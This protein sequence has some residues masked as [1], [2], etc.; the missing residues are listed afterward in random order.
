V[1]QQGYILNVNKPKG[2]TSFDV[3]RHVRQI[4]GIK[5][6]GHAGTLDPLAEGVLIILIGRGATK[7]SNE[8][9]GKRKT[10][11][12]TFRLGVKTRTHDLEAEIEVDEE[13]DISIEQVEQA[14]RTYVGN[15]KQ[16]PPMYS[17][18]KVNG[19][20]LYKLAKKG[21]KVSR[22]PVELTIHELDLLEKTGRDVRIQVS[23][24]KGTYIRSLARDLGH[25]LHTH[26]VV[27]DL[28]RI[29]V[30]EYT[31]EESIPFDKIEQEWNSIAA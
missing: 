13:V 19:T 5:K 16:I 31:L 17:A 3:V 22:E 26:A 10:Y 6:V 9:I 23:C 18:K 11:E 21:E 12:T 27:T 28:T 7:R 14:L 1:S 25:D 15:I 4:A 30:G 24:S 2:I 29:A 8:F 20:P